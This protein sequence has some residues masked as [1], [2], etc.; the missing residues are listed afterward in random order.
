M[1]LCC[2]DFVIVIPYHSYNIAS[3]IITSPV[4]PWVS[5]A[6]TQFDW[7]RV[8]FYRRVIIDSSPL[9]R[10]SLISHI[11]YQCL[12]SFTFLLLFGFTRETTKAYQNAFYWCMQPFGIKKPQRTTA[13]VNAKPPKRSWIDRLL[14]RDAIPLKSAISTTGSLPI[15]ASNIQNSKESRPI[16]SARPKQSPTNSATDTL[17][18]DDDMTDGHHSVMVIDGR[19]LTIPGLNAMASFDSEDV[20]DEKSHTTAK[21]P[22]ISYNTHSPSAV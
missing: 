17:N 12:I 3:S 15:F 5:W 19:R 11:G 8:D 13:I 16:P 9:L 10:Y 18:W 6:V 7:Y 1:W 21:P 20:Y 22:G 14:G 2:I 4:D